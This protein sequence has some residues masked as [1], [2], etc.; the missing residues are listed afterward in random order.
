MACLLLAGS[1]L[2]FSRDKQG[3]VAICPEVIKMIMFA[4]SHPA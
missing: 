4:V 3:D 2:L 1:V